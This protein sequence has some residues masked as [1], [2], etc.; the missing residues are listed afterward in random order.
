MLGPPERLCQRARLSHQTAAFRRKARR[1]R[2]RSCKR[3]NLR[4]R[5]VSERA[6][7]LHSDVRLFDYAQ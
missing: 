6:A 7:M 4:G 2:V 5:I 3:R 1:I